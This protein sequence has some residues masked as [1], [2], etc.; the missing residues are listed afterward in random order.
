MLQITLAKGI[1]KK[2]TA[3]TICSNILLG[4]HPRQVTHCVKV[5]SWKTHMEDLLLDRLGLADTI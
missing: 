4:E 3:N 5:T 2:I 1:N